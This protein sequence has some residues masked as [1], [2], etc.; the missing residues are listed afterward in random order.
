MGVVETRSR[1]ASSEPASAE[2]GATIT[3]S[4]TKRHPLRDPLRLP[5]RDASCLPPHAGETCENPF[6]NDGASNGGARGS[7]GAQTSQLT[8]TGLDHPTSLEPHTLPE[9]SPPT[10]AFGPTLSTAAVSPLLLPQPLLRWYGEVKAV[11]ARGSSPN[12]DPESAEISPGIGALAVESGSEQT[13]CRKEEGMIRLVHMNRRICRA[14]AV[15]HHQESDQG[16]RAHHEN[17]QGESRGASPKTIC[18]LVLPPP[19]LSHPM[20]DGQEGGQEGRQEGRLD[21]QKKKHAPRWRLDALPPPQEEPST[22]CT[23]ILC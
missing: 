16:E 8:P 21:G 18:N 9:P 6:H 7:F 4:K 22:Q 1:S 11:Y 2:K 20:P 12:L 19:V 14:A 5:A 3:P 23:Y 17:E 10:V 15:V 13:P